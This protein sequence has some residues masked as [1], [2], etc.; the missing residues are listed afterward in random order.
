MGNTRVI[1]SLIILI[2]KFYINIVDKVVNTIFWAC[3]PR[4]VRKNNN[5]YK[6]IFRMINIKKSVK[7]IK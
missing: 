7:W 6:T 5:L 2:N 3:P 1:L 4:S